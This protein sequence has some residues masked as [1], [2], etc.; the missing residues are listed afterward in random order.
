M[1]YNPLQRRGPDGRWIS[2]G[3][4]K[5]TRSVRKKANKKAFAKTRPAGK[6]VKRAKPKGLLQTA[7]E[8][9]ARGVGLAGLRKNII[10]HA[11]ISKR[12]T[13]VGAN[14]GSFVP[15]SNKRIAIG[16]YAR[17]ESVAKDTIVD[18]I[19]GKLA[20]KGSLR[21]RVGGYLYS[22][23]MSDVK[24]KRIATP[25]AFG[26]HGAEARIGT[27]RSAGPTLIFRKGVHKS[28]TP[29]TAKSGI[30]KYDKR[31]AAIQGKRVKEKKPRAS[32]RKK[33]KKK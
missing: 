33:S 29:K 32:R 11:R 8:R 22:G 4:K 6:K 23:A 31:M 18:K 10:P 21:K 20:P 25:M 16:G 3:T 2:S 9:N 28:S 5:V 27:S 17:I 13:T 15:F 30:E 24:G 26:R 1:S 7:A 14:T 19:V 12:S